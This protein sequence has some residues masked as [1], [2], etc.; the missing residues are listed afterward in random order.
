MRS[1]SSLPTSLLVL[2]A[3]VSLPTTF[4][5]DAELKIEKTVAASCS[6]PSRSGDKIAVN[7]RGTLQS[8]GVEFDASYNRGIPFKFTLGSGQVIKGWD[9]GL[10]DMCPGEGRRLIIPPGLGYGDRGAPP[11][12]PGGAT[13][14]FETELVDIEGVKQESLDIAVTLYAATTTEQSLSI[15][16]AP[17][18]PPSKAGE[19]AEEIGEFLEGT[20]LTDSAETSTTQAGKCNLL[21]PWALIVQGALG[22]VAVL[23]LVLKRW[24][25]KPKRPWKIWFFDVSKQVFGSVLLHAL[26]VFMSMLGAGGMD[27]A[28]QKTAS[29]DPEPGGGRNYPNPCSF[30]LLNLGIDTT[31][32]IPVLYLLLKILHVAFT[33]T[34]LA[35]PTQSIK[36]GN[37][38]SPPRVTWWLKQLLIYFLGL[39]GMKAFVLF[40]FAVLHW[41]PW[42]GDWALRWTEG[43]EALQIAF[44]MF[45]FPLL[46]NGIQYWII[47]S[48]IM[49][50]TRGEEGHGYERVRGSDVDDG[51]TE[52][53]L[54]DGGHDGEVVTEESVRGKGNGEDVRPP[55]LQEVNPTPIPADDSSV[56]GMRRE[57]DSQNGIPAKKA[58]DGA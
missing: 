22:A 56:T 39:T 43:N 47:D 42:L 25:E 29:K 7:Y 28:A 45:I 58:E 40:L 34:P 38:G 20:P 49:D 4:A 11:A 48:L 3:S 24:R 52:G 13:L 36:S 15:A 23:S 26:N 8:T 54:R 21:G 37:Y 2:I 31:I 19:I 5:D 32:G 33:Y 35:R 17:S 14:V 55:P 50:R 44:V 1:L 9:E 57:G 53:G 51:D 10:L 6:R 16:T 41:L 12:I 18:T 27:Q 46:M 30:Y